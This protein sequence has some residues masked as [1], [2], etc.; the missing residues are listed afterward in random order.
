MIK[1][2]IADDHSIVR[3]GLKQILSDSPDMVVAGE[4]S[5]GQEVLA[6]LQAD[7]WDLVVLD[8]SLPDHNGLEVL[9]QINS[10][11]PKLP[12][13]IL[14]MHAEEQY[15]VRALKAGAAGYMTKESAADQL[16][17]AIRKVA[18]GGKYVNPAIAEKLFFDLL[19]EP[20]QPHKT[21]SRREYQVFCMIASGKTIT[22]IAQELFL[23]VKT[24]STHRTRILQKMSMSNNAELI[25]YA[26]RNGLV[27]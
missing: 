10:L 8:I 21:L 23:S 18:Q 17:T 3:E 26:I 20:V 22:E 5:S 16:I 12:V 19:E 2:L 11:H 24:V 4:A 25:R 7:R 14:S 15:I 6:K 13:L 27:K 1:I 9:G